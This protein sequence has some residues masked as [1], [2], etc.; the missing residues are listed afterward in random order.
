MMGLG[1]VAFVIARSCPCL[2]LTHLICPHALLQGL[3]R[4]RLLL[5]AALFVYSCIVEAVVNLTLLIVS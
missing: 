2:L 3:V 5:L 1:F 4:T